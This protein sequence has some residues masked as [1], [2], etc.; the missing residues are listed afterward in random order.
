MS[1]T[2]LPIALLLGAGVLVVSVLAVRLSGRI[3]LPGLLFFLAFGL[4]LEQTGISISDPSLAQGLGLAGLV[5]ILAEGGLATSWQHIRR[6]IPASIALATVGIVLSMFLVAVAAHYLAGLEWRVA[7]LLGAILS[8]TDAAAVF[9]VLRKLPLPPHLSGMLE[10][11]SG[12]NDAPCVI[13]VVAFSTTGPLPTAWHLIAD[14]LF[15]LTVGSAIGIAVGW[16][17]A[18][19]VRRMALPASGLYPLTVLGLTVGVYGVAV[20]AHASGFAAVYL[21]GVVLGNAKLPHRAATRSFAEGIGWLAQIG[22]FVML[23]ITAFPERLPSALLPAL[24]VGVGLLIARPVAVFV[25]LAPFR[26]PWQETTFMS[27]AG[28]RGA[29][30]IVLATIPATAGVAGSGRLFD[31]VFVLVVLFTVLQAPTL[32]WLARKLGVASPAEPLELDVEAA[33][34]EDMRADML[35][36]SIPK[37]SALAGVEV[38]ELRLPKGAAVTLVVRDGAGFVPANDTILR[39]GD[40]LLVV[41]TNE[42]REATERRLRAVSR[43]GKLARWFGERGEDE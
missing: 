22:L 35:Q 29:M 31:V 6:A 10:A 42:A 41:A 28:L 13:L 24:L 38:F 8:S 15:E 14:A 36:L 18:R 26:R 20:L 33:P 34:L 5:V 4:V 40:E 11:E 32:P 27:W 2:V 17:G 3:G 30:P 19:M 12:F 23:G 25:A 7:L 9:S 39:T 16:L 43:R 1:E 21:A 37:G